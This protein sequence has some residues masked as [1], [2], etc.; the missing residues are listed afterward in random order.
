MKFIPNRRDTLF[1]PSFTPIHRLIITT[2]LIEEQELTMKKREN[3]VHLQ[4]ESRNVFSLDLHGMGFYHLLRNPSL[5][6]NLVNCANRNF[7]KRK[8]KC[9]LDFIQVTKWFFSNIIL[10]P[11]F[12]VI[13]DHPMMISVDFLEPF[14][15]FF[16][17]LIHSS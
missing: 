13:M 10:N 2:H 4:L 12:V 7:M 3:L 15:L 16:V 5:Y 14:L 11:N 9:F 8:L 6:Q 1:E 17:I